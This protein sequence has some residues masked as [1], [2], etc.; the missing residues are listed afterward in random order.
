MN[1]NRSLL[2]PLAIARVVHATIRRAV[3]VT[4]QSDDD[5]AVRVPTLCA[6]HETCNSIACDL[7]FGSLSLATSLVQCGDS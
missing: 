3:A 1:P 6:Q 7:D 5:M 4:G 2:F